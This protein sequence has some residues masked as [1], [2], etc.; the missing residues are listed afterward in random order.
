MMKR[1][2]IGAAMAVSAVMGVAA[3]AQ[4][5][6][7]VI[8][9][10]A[11]AQ[12][13]QTARNTLSQLQEAQ[14][15]YQAMN[16]LSNI[17]SVANVLDQPILRDALPDGMNS[18]L[19]LLSGDLHD[20]GAI[21]SR[22]ES[23]LSNGNYS[24]SGLDQSLG[25]AQGILNVSTRAAARDQAYSERMLEA[26]QATG[27]GLNQ[28]SDGLARATT[29]REATDIGARAAIEN[30]AVNNRM[31][32]MMAADRARAAQGSLRSASDYAETQRRNVANREA[33][34]RPTYQ[35]Q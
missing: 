4:A 28:L 14:R 23:I 20:L 19:D 34:R 16:S 12:A 29:L 11:V 6:V 5:Q 18:S 21:G 24:L 27:E 10:R 1:Q 8:D 30:T 32:Q 22:A 7:A 13:L 31:L 17:R 15:L 9:A 35:G 25:D 3:P 26:T 2:L 33:N